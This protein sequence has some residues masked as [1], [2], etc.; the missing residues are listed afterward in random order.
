MGL[1]RDIGEQVASESGSHAVYIRASTGAHVIVHLDPV[2][3]YGRMPLAD[4]T[5][6]LGGGSRIPSLVRLSSDFKV[7]LANDFRSKEGQAVFVCRTLDGLLF[8]IMVAVEAQL[9]DSGWIYMDCQSD[10]E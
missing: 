7:Q 9:A 2:P 4:L 6:L 5:V 10:V 1:F 8:T 3:A